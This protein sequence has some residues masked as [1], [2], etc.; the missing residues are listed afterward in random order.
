M[1]GKMQEEKDDNNDTPEILD[2]HHKIDPKFPKDAFPNNLGCFGIIQTEFASTTSW[3]L[4]ADQPFYWTVAKNRKDN[5]VL[6]SFLRFVESKNME[7]ADEFKAKPK[8]VSVTGAWSPPHRVNLDPK[9]RRLANI[10]LDATKFS[11]FY[12]A[13]EIPIDVLNLQKNKTIVAKWKENASVMSLIIGGYSYFNDDNQLLLENTLVPGAK[14]GLQFGPPLKWNHEFSAK[15]IKQER[16]HKITFSHMIKTGAIYFGWIFPFE[17]LFDY[18]GNSRVISDYGAFAYL[19]H[20]P[21]ETTRNVKW[22]MDRYFEVVPSKVEQSTAN[23]D[24]QY[25]ND[26]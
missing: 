2:E 26:K 3:P 25:E 16:F 11:W 18:D 8:T 6:A 21:A 5:S 10:P 17:E 1:E 19:W 24:Q 12:P 9:S 23:D 13:K 14:V 7:N 4:K 20:D 15:L 22:E